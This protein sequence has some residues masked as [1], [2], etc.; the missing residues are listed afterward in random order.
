MKGNFERCLDFVLR[1]EGGWSDHPKDPGGATMKGVTIG[2]FSSYLGRQA[3]KDELRNISDEQ[4]AD[5][6]LNRYW[7]KVRGDDLPVGV[8]LSVFDFAV[9]AGPRRS[10]RTL[11]NC[12]WVNDDG[13]IGPKTLKAVNDSN[14]KNL[15]VRFSEHRSDFYKSLRTFKVF[16]NGW[17]RRTFECEKESLVMAGESKP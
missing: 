10:A 14:S 15:I 7:L 5:I 12:V 3:T 6:Y 2:V 4:L 1:H 16:G 13:V 11:Q 17:L 8:D 9:N